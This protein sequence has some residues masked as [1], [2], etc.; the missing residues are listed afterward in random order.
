MKAH[1]VPVEKDGHGGP[2]GDLG[3]MPDYEENEIS[4]PTTKAFFYELDLIK[5][6]FN[7]QK[8]ETINKR[9]GN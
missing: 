7:K 6:L 5:W 8:N 3:R 1:V 2:R 9:T 4:L